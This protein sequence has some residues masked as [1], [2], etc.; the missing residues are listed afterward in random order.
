MA[1]AQRTQRRPGAVPVPALVEKLPDHGD[2]PGV[3][4]HRGRPAEDQPG[5]PGPL[6]RHHVEIVDNLH[7]VADETD[8]HH[9]DRLGPPGRAERRQM[10]ADVRHQPRHARRAAA[11]GVDQ[12]VRVTAAGA[13]RHPLDD[14][15]GGGGQLPGVGVPVRAAVRRL[16]ERDRVC[17]EDQP[18]LRPRPGRDR[19]QLADDMVDHG[20]DETGM[21]EVLPQLDQF[22][23][24]RAEVGPRPRKI[25]TVLAA[26]GVGGEG[27]RHEAGRP[28]DAVPP[29]RLER[30]DEER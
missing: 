22:R 24:V 25:L 6:R 28:A 9:H 13:Q 5:L 18:R 21:V 2:E 30:V 19:G 10:V 1:G 29:H 23:R 26:A 17:D 20:Q 7:V 14:H 4:T 16:R 15:L 3:D 27:G 12:V 11:A 8:R